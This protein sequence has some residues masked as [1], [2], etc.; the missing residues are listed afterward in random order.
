MSTEWNINTDIYDILNSVKNVQKRYIEDEDET[1]LSLGVFGFIADTE[2]KKIQTATIMT[3]QLGNEM[4]PTRAV[5]TKNV[6]THAAY[7]GIGNINAVPATITI[8]LCVKM[9]DIDTNMSNT[10]NGYFYLDS[11]CPIFIDNY[12]FH[13]DYDVRITRKKVSTDNNYS[14]AAQYIMEDENGNRIINRLSN[15]TNPYIK[16]PF[17][18]NIGNEQYLSIQCTVRQITIETTQ[19]TM[20]SNSIAENKTYTFEFFNQIADFR[21]RVKDGNEVTEL[22]P[23]LYGSKI[24]DDVTN[25]CWYLF[26]GDNQIRITFDNKSYIPGLNSDIEIIAYTTLG[27]KGNFNYIKIDN[28]SSGLYVDMRSIKYG[29]NSIITYMIAMTDSL[30]GQDRKTKEELQKLIPKAAVS[31]GSITTETDIENYLTLES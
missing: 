3:G 2:A 30:N 19:D 8:T 18:L 28:T 25:Y 1:T 24:D 13:L 11:E 20:K 10:E 27:E 31:R 23:Y 15:I 17:I 12:E 9:S 5:L 14:F 21:V 4:F 29:Y 7:N 22:T 6:L 16:Q 26:V